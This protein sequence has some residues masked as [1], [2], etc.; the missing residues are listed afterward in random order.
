MIKQPDIKVNKSNKQTIFEGLNLRS[1]NIC[2]RYYL[3]NYQ[4]GFGTFILDYYYNKE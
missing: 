3:N 4:L 1:E 2:D